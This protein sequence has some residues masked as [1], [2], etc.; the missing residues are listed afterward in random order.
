MIISCGGVLIFGTIIVL[1]GLVIIFFLG[2]RFKQQDYKNLADQPDLKA[3][4]LALWSLFSGLI[5]FLPSVLF[6]LLTIETI[7]SPGSMGDFQGVVFIPLC[8]LGMA[9][10]GL[11]SVITGILELRNLLKAKA[12][13]NRIVIAIGGIFL[14]LP[15]TF[16]LLYLIYSRLKI[17][18]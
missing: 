1:V 14:G 12:R 18:M 16:N 10:V 6:T 9:P 8:M 13:D 7:R 11:S 3:S 4:K 5:S 2:R 15:G 17:T